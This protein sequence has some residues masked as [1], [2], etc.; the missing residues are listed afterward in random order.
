MFR[1]APPALRVFLVGLVVVG[2]QFGVLSN[3]V[4][5]GH[6]PQIVLALAAAAGAG[7]GSER[8]AIAGFA[9]GLMVD[10]RGTE[11]LGMTALAYALAGLTAGYVMSITPDPQWWLAAIFT[12]LGTAV[13]ETAI[14]VLKLITGQDGWLTT[15]VL[16]VLLVVVPFG[17]LLSPLLV[18][19]GRWITGAKRPKWKVILE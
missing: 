7:G 17:A 10:L 5:A 13:G 2:I 11:A 1:L 4:I 14:P 16:T 9:L 6:T 15:R 19:V 8:G 18:P 3:V 12:T